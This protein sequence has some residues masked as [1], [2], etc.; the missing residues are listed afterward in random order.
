VLLC[1]L[2]MGIVCPMLVALD[3]NGQVQSSTLTAMLTAVCLF[4]SQHDR[5]LCHLN[6]G[7]T[8]WLHCPR[9]NSLSLL[10]RISDLFD[11]L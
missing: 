2:T 11:C 9:C 8:L 7:G 10:D 5:L 4:V 6:D 1:G 3:G